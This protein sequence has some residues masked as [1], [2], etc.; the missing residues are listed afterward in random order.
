MLRRINRSPATV[1]SARNV[2]SGVFNFALDEGYLSGINPAHGATRN[3]GLEKTSSGDLQIFTVA[4]MN[5]ALDAIKKYR[6]RLYPLF[7]LLFRSGLRLGEALALDLDDINLKSGYI[8]VRKTFK[9]GVISKTKTGKSRQVD[10][11]DDLLSVIT[12]L[13][14]TVVKEI[15]SGPSSNHLFKDKS[16]GR[17]SQNTA[18]GIWTRCLS[19]AGVEYRKIHATRHTFASYLLS[20]GADLFYVS[21]MLGHA[22]IQMTSDVYGH[23]VPDRDRSIINIIDGQ[24]GQAKRSTQRKKAL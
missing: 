1:S 2:I 3:L 5:A 23:L 21:K 17:L 13:K 18:R 16:G 24:L 7:F 4:E 15:L 8:V 11:S 20:G 9:K 10:M 22:N 19:T 14:A 12:K 6:P